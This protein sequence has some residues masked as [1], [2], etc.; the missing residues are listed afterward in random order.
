MLYQ[1]G[2]DDILQAM[3]YDRDMINA[4]RCIDDECDML[5]GDEDA[6]M[7]NRSNDD[8]VCQTGAMMR[9]C[10]TGVM[11]MRICQQGR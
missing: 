4:D 6:D 10:Q 3:K 8:A 5:T 2:L 11:M 7:P 9:L 1:I